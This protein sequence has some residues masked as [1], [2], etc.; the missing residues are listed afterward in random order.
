[1]NKTGVLVPVMAI[2]LAGCAAAQSPASDGAATLAQSIEVAGQGQT[3]MDETAQVGEAATG[4]S[5]TAQEAVAEPRK[6]RTIVIPTMYESVTSKEEAD[7][8]AKTNGYESATLG[9]D[10]SLTIVMEEDVYQRMIDE[11]MDSVE[12]GTREIVGDGPSVKKI[13]Y[14]DDLSVFTVSVDTDE[15]GIIERQAAEELV[16][17][18][19][20]YH[21]YTGNNVD[22]IQVD[23]VNEE[24]GDVIESADS[25][26]LTGA[27]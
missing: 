12:K 7:E 9:E 4:A 27:Y 8:I 19:T 15:I 22:H 10:G 18:G 26:S 3:A 23:F 20:L 6:R 25:G 16:M 1:M 24:S 5:D 13:T 11:F 14:T 21:I 2:L 17:Y